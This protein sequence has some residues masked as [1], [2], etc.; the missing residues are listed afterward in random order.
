MSI[1]KNSALGIVGSQIK[2]NMQSHMRGYSNTNVSGISRSPEEEFLSF[3]DWL[4]EFLYSVLQSKQDLEIYAKLNERELVKF[5]R[6][7]NEELISSNEFTNAVLENKQNVVR[8]ISGPCIYSNILAYYNASVKISYIPSISDA[9]LNI[10]RIEICERKNSGLYDRT[11]LNGSIDILDNGQIIKHFSIDNI[12]EQ[13]VDSY[14]GP[15]YL[16]DTLSNIQYTKETQDATID[17]FSINRENLEAVCHLFGSLL[18][19]AGLSMNQSKALSMEPSKTLSR[20]PSK[21]K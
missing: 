11:D 20:K 10:I 4:S 7:T 9:T 14:K 18:E 15:V 21:T 1:S 13:F 2:A 3:S 6:D 5:L 8:K 16:R 19:K 12:H 17:D